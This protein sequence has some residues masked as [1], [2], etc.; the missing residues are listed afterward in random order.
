[1][2]RD[3]TTS[4]IVPAAVTDAVHLTSPTS[5]GAF[6]I[7]LT[8]ICSTLCFLSDEWFPPESRQTGRKCSLGFNAERGANEEAAVLRNTND[9]SWYDIKVHQ[10]ETS[11]CRYTLPPSLYPLNVTCDHQLMCNCDQCNL[12]REELFK[13]NFKGSGT[14]TIVTVLHE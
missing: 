2:Q 7:P 1:M 3:H 12:A 5:S 9:L 13:P 10:T 4:W 11:H 8:C 6:S 14:D